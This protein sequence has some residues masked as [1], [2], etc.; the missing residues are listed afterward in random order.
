MGEY[1][2]QESCFLE[3]ST[4]RKPPVALAVC[5]WNEQPPHSDGGHGVFTGPK[6]SGQVPT[7]AF[8]TTRRGEVHKATEDLGSGIR[9]PVYFQ[10][11]SRD[12]YEDHQEQITDH[13]VPLRK[14]MGRQVWR[15]ATRIPSMSDLEAC[16]RQESGDS[17][18]LRAI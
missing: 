7:E 15:P 10:Q 3:R 2:E 13:A 9:H 12:C 6:D 8:T 5:P 14:I 11:A 17:S 16:T 1:E 18:Y 4:T